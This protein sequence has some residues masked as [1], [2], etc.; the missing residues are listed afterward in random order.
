MLIMNM[1]SWPAAFVFVLLAF[2][3]ANVAWA[4]DLYSVT[5]P[6]A[7]GV[8]CRFDGGERECSRFQGY[9]FV[10]RGSGVNA[11]SDSESSRGDAALSGERLYLG[12]NSQSER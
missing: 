2:G 12:V 6:S 3:S 9:V 8:V 5:P 4:D 1:R 11:V 10:H 7:N